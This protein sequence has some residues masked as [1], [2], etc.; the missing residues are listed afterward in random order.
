[1]YISLVVAVPYPRWD[2]QHV[3]H[4]EEEPYVRQVFPRT[5]A[6]L[7]NAL[8]R[9]RDCIQPRC[10]KTRQSLDRKCFK[11]DIYTG[12]GGSGH[13]LQW[14]KRCLCSAAAAAF[15][16]S[17][18]VLSSLLLSSSTLPQP[19][20]KLLGEYICTRKF[21]MRLSLGRNHLSHNS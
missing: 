2:L 13:T 12:G 9:P 1:M 4:L 18:I 6:W 11:I 16:P 19:G 20:G 5:P 3:L 8:R 14:P 17:K 15:M 21:T 10:Q 7:Q